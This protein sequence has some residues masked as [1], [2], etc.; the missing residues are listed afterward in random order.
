[1]SNSYL[2]AMN[3]IIS[4]RVNLMENT[5][6]YGENLDRGSFISGMS[7]NLIAGSTRL[8]KNVGNCEYLKVWGMG[9]LGRGRSNAANRPLAGLSGRCEVVR[10]ILLV[11]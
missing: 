9:Y 8:V 10:Q 11:K 2:Q 6:V 1:M 7:K 4:D 3:K 5:L